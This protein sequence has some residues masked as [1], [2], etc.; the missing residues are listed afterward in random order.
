MTLRARDVMETD[1]LAVAPTLSL[2]DLAD[3][4]IRERVSGVPVVAAGELVGHVSRSDLVRAGSLERSLAGLAAEA[5]DPPEFA[6]ASEPALVASLASLAPALKARTVRDIM[7]T[8]VLTVTP[9]TPL[10]EVA[11][12][13]LAR[14]LHRV[15]VTEGRR[16]RGVIS[17]LDLVRLI[18]DERL[19]S[20]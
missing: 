6:P 8:E 9:E 13:L 2:I 17:A 7:V 10:T 4:L 15:L 11:R 20:P 3:F 14:H 5:V 18:A 19:R 16:V 1:V 12:L